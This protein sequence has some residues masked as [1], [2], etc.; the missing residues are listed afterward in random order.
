[1]PPEDV[2]RLVDIEADLD[3]GRLSQ[4]WFGRRQFLRTLG[5]ALFGLATGMVAMPPE[6]Q[7][8]PTPEHCFGAPGCPNCDSEGR[9]RHKKC[10]VANTCWGDS[11]WTVCRDGFIYQCCDSWYRGGICMCRK[12]IGYC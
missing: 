3:E 11:C 8:R 10:T 2:R 12:V 9:C 4:V 6:A 1:M 5:L 7:A